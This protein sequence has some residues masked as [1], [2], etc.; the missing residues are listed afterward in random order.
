MSLKRAFED[1][2]LDYLANLCHNCTACYYDCQ[3]ADPHEFNVNVPVALSELRNQSY[4]RYAWPAGLAG[5][6]ERN[7]LVVAL[8]T[9]LLLA[10]VLVIA[11]ALI[12]PEVLFGVHTGPGAFYNVISHDVMVAVA[13]ATFGFSVIAMSI[14][15]R[16]YWR[17]TGKPMQAGAITRALRDAATMKNLDGGHGDGCHVSEDETSND[18]RLFHQLTMWGFLLCFAATSVATVYDYVFGWIAPYP[19][20]SLPVLLGTT[21]GIGLLIGPV[22]LWL[23]KQRADKRPMRVSQYGMDYAFLALLFLVSSTGL[24]LLVIRDTALM[25]ATLAV[26]L[27]FVLALFVMLPYSKFVHAIYRFA[28]LIRFHAERS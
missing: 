1:T 7:G 21:G 19:F 15:A 9:A 14:G 13:G 22:G 20:F 24:L 10:A 17:A 18:R 16:R 6:F 11:S 23:V 8:V 3:Y 28:A 12:D 26:H 4:Q 27:G 5:L 2:D 25:G